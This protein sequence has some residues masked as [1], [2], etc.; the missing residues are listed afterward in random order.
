MDLMMAVDGVRAV[1]G[2]SRSEVVATGGAL[3]GF[4]GGVVLAFAASRELAAHRLA[5]SALYLETGLL[6]AAHIDPSA[7]VGRI[8]G[9]DTHIEAGVR[10]NDW[11]TRIGI[12]LL[13]LSLALTV[14]AFFAKDPPPLPAPPQKF[15]C[16]PAPGAKVGARGEATRSWSV[17][18]P[19]K[20][21]T[22]N[23]RRVGGSR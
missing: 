13:L 20:F 14:G 4:A 21:A 12:G 19:D 9:T 8:A 1:A 18:P 15:I 5:L 22:K 10:V 11:L 16:A 6:V 23:I 17:M 3:F 2:M 7:E